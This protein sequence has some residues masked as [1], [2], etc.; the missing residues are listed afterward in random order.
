MIRGPLAGRAA[1]ALAAALAA[2]APRPASAAPPPDGRA[3]LRADAALVLRADPVE[4]ERV[5]VL[6]RG[7]GGDL[8]L[9]ANLLSLGTAT[10]LG[11]DALAVA[12]WRSVGLDPGRPAFLQISA[13][14]PR[15]RPGAAGVFRHARLVAH[16]ADPVRLAGWAHAVPVLEQRWSPGRAGDLGALLGA[17][18]RAA[19]DAA[20]DL[21]DRGVLAAGSA[22]P[23]GVLVFLRQEGPLLVIDAVVPPR[24]VSW[25]RDRDRVL[26]HLSAP[27]PAAAMPGRGSAGA[28]LLARP[29]LV[30]WTRAG[31]PSELLPG[32]PRPGGTCAALRD[33]AADSSLLD[34]AAAIHIAPRRLEAELVW[35]VADD[36]PVAAAFPRADDGLLGPPRRGGAI[37]SAALYLASTDRL[38]ALPRGALVRAGWASFWHHVEA[39][40]AGA[41]LDAQLFLWPQ[42]AAQWL[43]EIAAVHPA[44][45]TLVSAVRNAAVSATRVSARDRRDW[46]AVAEVSLSPAGL[47][48]AERILDAVFGRRTEQR[49]PRAHHLWGAGPIR[50]YALAAGRALRVIGAGAGVESVIWRMR[51]GVPGRRATPAALVRLAGDAGALLR[52]LTP[53]LPPR[54]AI[55]GRAAAARVGS[56]V[57]DVTAGPGR[58][59]AAVQL[60]LE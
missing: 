41:R 12:G 2:L 20:R 9:A 32:G 31:A 7:L 34:A 1:L 13:A 48:P 53:D 5:A 35:G 11:F 17:T 51:R 10:A 26:A 57:G 29:G 56:F 37:A 18:G 60:R 16:V 46:R 52:Q 28:L 6:A 50:P 54:L 40:G 30:L 43:E 23:L 33:L 45:A 44:G 3:L 38:R 22:A 36:A 24:P 15:A 49:R 58:I 4:L 42:L 14:G 27:D 21:R 19:A 47:P 59:R 55:I 8:G 25:A 39:C